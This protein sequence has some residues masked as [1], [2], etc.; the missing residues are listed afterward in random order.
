MLKS[1]SGESKKERYFNHLSK[2]ITLSR[3]LLFA[4]VIL[5]NLERLMLR[6]TT[7]HQVFEY[8]LVY[9]KSIYIL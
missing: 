1:H 5:T 8:I 6:F 3:R 9:C 4:S 2:I 7:Q